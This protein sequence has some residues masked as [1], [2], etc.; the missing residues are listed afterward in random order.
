MNQMRLKE[1]K[2]EVTQKCPLNCIHCSS[3]ANITKTAEL[4][5][6]I[7]SRLIKEAA[8][9]G[10]QE[11]TFSGGEPLIWPYIS[12]MIDHCN[13]FKMRPVV[14]TSGNP[15][16]DGS[17]LINLQ[18]L[19]KVSKVT[20]SIFGSTA[21]SHEA[22]TR[23]R[24]S[25]E[26]SI[27]A[28]KAISSSFTSVG[29]HFVAMK[30]NWM[31]IEAVVKLA[32]A[33]SVDSVSVLRFVPHGRGSMVD[34]YNL[35]KTELKS[36][37]NSIIKL[38]EKSKAYIRTGSPFNI[39]LLNRNV[40]CTAGIDRLIIDPNGKIYPCDAFKNINFKGNLGSIIE[41]SLD[42]IWNGSDYLNKV[43]KLI[44]EGLG[45]ECSKC[46]NKIIC[47]GGCLAQKVIRIPDKL[48]GPDPDCLL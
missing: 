32:N 34:Y 19:S 38:R 13:S 12:S 43:R 44:S 25:F 40:L 31:E 18:E 29:I 39:L 48:L 24:G 30:P 47:K 1:L 21:N 16:I 37:R 14:Y 4:S 26:K 5:Y 11:I 3:E 28:I 33:L 45:P 46:G 41:N 27:C 10:V 9:I 8:D 17:S 35:S 2:I 15:I 20:I 7:V 23:I 42:D 6:N 22:I 36:L